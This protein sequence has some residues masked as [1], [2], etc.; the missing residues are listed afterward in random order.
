ME[1]Y[2]CKLCWREFNENGMSRNAGG[3][4]ADNCLKCNSILG[5]GAGYGAE[6]S[7][8]EANEWLK[9]WKDRKAE[10]DQKA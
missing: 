9:G 8:E 6:V 10:Y 7:D 4:I 2:T 5:K 3:N 1:I